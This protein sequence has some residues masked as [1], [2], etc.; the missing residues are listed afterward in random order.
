MD[1]QDT[2]AEETK[3][4]EDSS[5]S[6]AS[7][8]SQDAIA[9]QMKAASL[10]S[11]ATPVLFDAIATRAQLQKDFISQDKKNDFNPQ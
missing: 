3:V 1:M 2:N 8:I 9:E 6:H 11:N 5:P 7:S 4:D 10:A